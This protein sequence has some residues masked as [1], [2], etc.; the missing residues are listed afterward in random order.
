[1]RRAARQQVGKLAII[2]A[3]VVLLVGGS[4]GHQK[5]RIAC[6]S[7]MYCMHARLVK[8]CRPAEF[9]SAS[10]SRNAQESRGIPAFGGQ[11]RTGQTQA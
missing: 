11:P 8:L 2:A 3:C 5:N 6:I 9:R 10:E 1:V 7:C 4:C